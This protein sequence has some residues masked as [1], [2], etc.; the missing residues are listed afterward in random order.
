[1]KILKSFAIVLVLLFST[2]TAFAGKI[3]NGSFPSSSKYNISGNV[4][5]TKSGDKI[6][7]K[8][9]NGYT[10]GAAPDPYV[11]LGKGGQPVS[12][13]IIKLL[14]KQGGQSVTFSAKNIDLAK[15]DSVIIWCKKYAVP[16]AVA[17]IK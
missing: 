2:G 1:M 14:T 15:V 5:V 8:L 9:G 10:M 12:G 16:L 7:I 17:K 11:S 6:T 3:G 4:K 13:G